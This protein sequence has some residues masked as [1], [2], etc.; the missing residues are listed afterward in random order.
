MARKI[1]C[2]GC[3]TQVDETEANK[4]EFT[5]VKLAKITTPEQPFQRL[6]I[7]STCTGAIR[8]ALQQLGVRS[9]G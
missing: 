5:S 3:G 2:D 8:S 4:E 7:C 1:Q 9:D 6:E